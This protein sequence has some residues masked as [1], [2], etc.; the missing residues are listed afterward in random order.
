MVRK[1]GVGWAFRGLKAGEGMK[2]GQV[3]K[4]PG[5]VVHAV[6]RRQDY[7][8]LATNLCVPDSSQPSHLTVW[9]P[10]PPM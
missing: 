5:G 10:S 4:H 3:A 7:N 9:G 8:L 1:V 6:E 2:W